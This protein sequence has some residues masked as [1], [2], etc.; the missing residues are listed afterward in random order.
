MER[1]PTSSRNKPYLSAGRWQQFTEDIK[2]VLVDSVRMADVNLGMCHKEVFTY[3]SKCKN[4]KR[5]LLY[6]ITDD[7]GADSDIVQ[8]VTSVLPK[9][10]K[11]RWLDIRDVYLEE[12]GKSLLDNVNAP[13]LRVLRLTRTH[14]EGNGGAL[15]SCLS[16]LRLLSS[17]DLFNSGL[18][19][20]E[21]NQVV[22]V[23]ST[24][25]PNIQYLDI[26]GAPFTSVELNP[27]FLLNHLRALAFVPSSSEDLIEALH[28]LPKTLQMLYP[29]LNVGVLHRLQE[30]ISAIR[31]LP[32]LR[33][34]AVNEG[35]LD[36]EGEQKVSDVLKQ[37]GGSFVVY[38]TDPQGWQDYQAQVTILRNECF[39]AT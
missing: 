4:T 17:L 27:V 16:R 15:T 10:A 26:I 20:T 28:D 38:I 5:L 32:R 1:N 13:D 29:A 8:E 18:S 11:L 33:F 12:R 34:L 36:S 30:F 22:Q 9:L 14:L 24:S 21:L 23:L 2:H 35:C 31:S 6:D 7:S 3:I 19:E 25:C 37:T 39:N